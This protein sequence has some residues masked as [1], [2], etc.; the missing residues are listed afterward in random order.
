MRK[1]G[2]SNKGNV[3]VAIGSCPSCPLQT[4]TSSSGGTQC[5]ERTSLN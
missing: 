3:G 1:G 4:G 2:K 5:L